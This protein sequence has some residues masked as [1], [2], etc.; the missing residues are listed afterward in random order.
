[1]IKIIHHIWAWLKY[2]MKTISD[3][4]TRNHGLFSWRI[5][6][7]S[8]KK[9]NVIL[10]CVFNLMLIWVVWHITNSLLL[11]L[12]RK[13]QQLQNRFQRKAD[14]NKKL[15]NQLNKIVQRSNENW[16]ELNDQKCPIFVLTKRLRCEK[17]I[18]IK[19]QVIPETRSQ[20]V[21]DLRGFIKLLYN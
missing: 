12:R 13:L 2:W 10:L 1:M 5:C 19:N 3:L 9:A 8:V 6:M 21:L 17:W 15:S 16:Q 4:L 20:L 11:Q 14:R 18:L 7:W